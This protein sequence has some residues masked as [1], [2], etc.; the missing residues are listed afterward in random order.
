MGYPETLMRNA[1]FAAFVLAGI[2]PLASLFTA[3]EPIPHSDPW[4]DAR[5]AELQCFAKG[6]LEHT[7][8][9]SMIHYVLPEDVSDHGLV[10]QRIRYL[11]PGRY[12]EAGAA[13]VAPGQ[14]VA[15]WHQPPP[16]GNVVWSGCGGVLLRR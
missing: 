1:L 15:A 9:R 10:T 14:Y 6:V 2:L 8:S 16:P 13:A 4:W 12:F 7:E 5:H 11:V 3:G